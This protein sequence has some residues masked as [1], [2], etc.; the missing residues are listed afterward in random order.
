MQKIPVHIITGF[1]GSGKTTF[2][3]HLIKE[4]HPHERI[5]VIEN[6]VGACN[7]DGA[8]VLPMAN[9]VVELTAG[10][11]CCSLNSELYDVL[12]HVSERREEYDRLIIE[13]T[14]VAD[15]SSIVRTFLGDPMV[16]RVFKLENVICLAD[17]ALVEDWIAE[18]DE[19]RRQVVISDIILLNK[20]DTVTPDY[21][22]KTK[23]ALI[24]LNPFAE[25]RTGNHGVFPVDEVLA[26]A[27]L[28]QPG[29]EEKSEKISKDHK[30]QVHGITTFTL[31]FSEPFNLE[32]LVHEMYKLINIYSHQ[33]YRIK[34]FVDAKG[35]PVKVI[36]QSVK[37][38]LSLEDGSRWEPGETR[39]SKI[40]FIGKGVK[41]ESIEKIF[42][43]HLTKPVS[44]P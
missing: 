24:G 2:L 22:Q 38:T 19:A 44:A 4:R 5:F 27:Q 42:K 21:L 7:I 3:N 11:L 28:R 12:E 9:E 10:C 14:G 30:H 39:E 1:L 17:A 34:G 15:P 37:N 40:V 33:V 8:L 43:R 23:S 20:A 18:T 36:L 31:S 32:M 6:E 41:R 35:S 25:V 13:T 26:T 16:E 29:I